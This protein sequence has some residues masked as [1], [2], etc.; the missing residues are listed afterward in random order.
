MQIEPNVIFGLAGLS[1]AA[2]RGLISYY[3][4]KKEK[5]KT[6][7]DLEYFGDTIV[8]GALTGAAFGMAMPLN[9]VSVLATAMSGAGV[10]TYT[11]RLGISIVPVVSEYARKIG[12]TG[13]KMLKLK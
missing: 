13:L 4:T 9:W 5:P 7:F 6:K 12:D 10:D 11:N 1:G 2:I 8:K 3:Q